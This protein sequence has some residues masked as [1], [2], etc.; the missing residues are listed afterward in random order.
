MKP[1]AVIKVRFKTAAEGGRHRSIVIAEKGHYGC[2]LFVDGQAFDC[3]F[4][5][6]AQTLSLG[7]TYELPVK[8]LAPDLA[9]SK[10]SPGKTVTL[11]EG[12]EIATGQVVRLE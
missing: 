3:R 12:G 9:L 4:L 6:E 7:E 2:P 10:L 1:D 5:V 8:F 11:W